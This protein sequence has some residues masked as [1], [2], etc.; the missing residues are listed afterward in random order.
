M[1]VLLIFRG[2]W[3]WPPWRIIK[4][5]ITNMWSRVQLKNQA[6]YNVGRY[7]WIALVVCFVAALLGAG[8]SNAVSFTS[9]L[10]TSFTNSYNAQKNQYSNSAINSLSDEQLLGIL[11]VLMIVFLVVFIL[12]IL[13]GTFIGAPV[14]VGKA[15]FFMESREMSA[16]NA[17]IGKLF[18]NFSHGN[19]WNTVKTMF[20][21]N[22]FIN[23]WSLLFVIP[24]I[25]K[26]YEYYMVPYIL[27]ENPQIHYRDALNLSKDMMH[28]QKMNT[29]IMELSFIGWIFLGMLACGIGIYFVLPYY[30]ATFAELYAVLRTTVN[31]DLLPGFGVCQEYANPTPGPDDYYRY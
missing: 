20:L 30:E 3:E 17:G 5:G 19:Y 11:G 24:G 2:E 22:L 8:S 1:N 10:G 16:G 27:A 9:S 13:F 26:S 28:G 12:V 25:I 6:K 29:F 21:K 23:L 31:T 7:Y 15:R 4:K 14:M 18:Q